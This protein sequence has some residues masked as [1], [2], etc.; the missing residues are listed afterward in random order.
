M[1]YKKVATETIQA[2][3]HYTAKEDEIFGGEVL[4][5]RLTSALEASGVDLETKE[6]LKGA[7]YGAPDE[8]LVELIRAI[9]LDPAMLD[10]A[11]KEE[12]DPGVS[13]IQ[14]DLYTALNDNPHLE[15]S[16]PEFWQQAMDVL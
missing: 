8:V 12:F 1:D 7:W 3:R 5:E 10:P 6:D 11:M 9:I 13:R 15:E 16:H 2:V 14:S 4:A